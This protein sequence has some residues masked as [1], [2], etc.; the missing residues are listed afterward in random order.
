MSED[1]SPYGVET[2]QEEPRDDEKSKRRED[3][4]GK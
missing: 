3:R 1:P 2:P 4:V